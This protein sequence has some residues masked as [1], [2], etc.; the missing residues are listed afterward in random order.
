MSATPEEKKAPAPTDS[1][2]DVELLE[3]LK[4]GRII[5]LIEK[6]KNK[7]Q[8]EIMP[9]SFVWKATGGQVL[10][11]NGAIDCNAKIMYGAQHPD[12]RNKGEFSKRKTNPNIDEFEVTYGTKSSGTIGPLME[13]FMDVTWPNA[14][15][16]YAATQPECC[17][18]DVTI[19]PK[20]IL[21]KKLG[22]A[23]K[24]ADPA[25]QAAYAAAA[26]WRFQLK[27]HI[28]AR[29]KKGEIDG[30]VFMCK[31][32]KYVT[33]RRRELEEKEIPV[34]SHNVH[35]TL[36]SGSTIQ[37]LLRPGNISCKPV[38]LGDKTYWEFYPTLNNG[39]IAILNQATIGVGMVPKRDQSTIIAKLLAAGADPYASDEEE[40]APASAD[41][42]PPAQAPASA[43][44]ATAE[45][46][47]TQFGNMALGK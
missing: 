26:D 44:P 9:S 27:Y 17:G 31:I 1:M 22:S 32:V 33:N 16:T 11:R 35:T 39:H 41:A 18:P 14:V 15:K 10:T 8:K 42:P 5:L 4:A 23:K 29:N 46:L 34:G 6:K 37:L 43:G 19:V 28:D 13:Y 40:E 2:T 47:A 38:V 7:D 25:D 20:S 12:N 30:K 3:H 36:T 45:D 21:K 24:P